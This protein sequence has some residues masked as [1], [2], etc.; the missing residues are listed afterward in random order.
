MSL[1]L[2]I[3]DRHSGK[4]SACRRL[5]ESAGARG[6][7]VGGILATALYE[8]GD[9]IGYEVIDLA[10]GQSTRLATT[11]GAGVEQAGR[12]HF[13]AEGL[14]LGRAALERTIEAAPQLVIVDEVGQLELEGGGW[15]RQVDQLAAE[16]SGLTLL[17]VRRQL[18]AR[19]AQRWSLPPGPCYD[20]AQGPGAVIEA[21]IRR[22]ETG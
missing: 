20:L 6:L 11:A 8:S 22:T 17:V 14:V 5:V 4:T 19:V 16:R 3:G 12:F 15:S 10:T 9:C 18:A 13:L 1:A 21:V 2:L 7:T